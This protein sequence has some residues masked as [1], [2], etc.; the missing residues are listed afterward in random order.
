[1]HFQFGFWL[2]FCQAVKKMWLVCVYVEFLVFFRMQCLWEPDRLTEK[3]LQKFLMQLSLVVFVRSFTQH[4]LAVISFFLII[5][6]FCKIVS[7]YF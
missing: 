3:R 7:Y 1:M 2:I 5:F 6:F 4:A